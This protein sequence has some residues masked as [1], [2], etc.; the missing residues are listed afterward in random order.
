MT[1][2]EEHDRTRCPGGYVGIDDPKV[3]PD[4]APCPSCGRV[5]GFHRVT[6]RFH[7][8]SRRSAHDRVLAEY[9]NG[10]HLPAE[11][12]AEVMAELRTVALAD[13]RAFGCTC[14]PVLALTNLTVGPWHLPAWQSTHTPTC[15]L[16][17][18]VP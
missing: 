18:L 7:N 5:I 14:D 13:A 2:P 16:D 11:L 3:G 15:G 9:P 6:G 8:H 4:R 17:R 10:G 1:A 12:L